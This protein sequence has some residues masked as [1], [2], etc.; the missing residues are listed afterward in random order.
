VAEAIVSKVW[1]GSSGQVIIPG[2]GTTLT[3]LSAL[4]HWYQ[5][6]LK[7]KGTQIMTN[8]KGR[9]V[10]DLEKWKVDDKRGPRA[11][12]SLFN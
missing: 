6:G 11:R 9:Q 8:W 1:A 3:F 5:I 4:P 7:A 12:E 10:I 2:F